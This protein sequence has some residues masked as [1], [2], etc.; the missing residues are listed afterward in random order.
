MAVYTHRRREMTP[1][2]VMKMIDHSLLHPT[3]TDSELEEECRIAAQTG[4]YSVCV[5]P[6]HVAM[7][8]S[9]LRES[10]VMVC[11]VV[12][13][14]HGNSKTKVKVFEAETALLDGADEI[15][16]V[17]N[18]GWV[19]GKNWERVT[20]EVT[21][22]TDLVHRDHKII[23]VIFEN[24]LLPDDETKIELCRICNK[25]NADF[26][27][28]STG[29]NYLKANDGRFFYN[30]ATDADLQLMRKHSD[31][32]IQIKAAGGVGSLQAILRVHA[33]GVTR[34]GTKRTVEILADARRA[35]TGAIPPE[36]DRATGY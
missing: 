21:Q 2:Q 24:D 20:E 8:S 12:G 4:C 1:E 13:F 10:G 11:A 31:P 36:D 33:L 9:L 14:P 30:G 26:V 34:V 6:Y 15:D 29:Y 22:L 7:A 5:K 27:K 17:P 23:K 32:H 19:A 18:L 3:L 25:A 16:M 35:E 28:T